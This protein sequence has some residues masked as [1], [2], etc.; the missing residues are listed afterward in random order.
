MM[1]AIMR[2]GPDDAALVAATLGGDGEA[3]GRIVARYQALICSLAYSATGSL[4]QGQDIAQETFVAAWRQ[5]RDLREPAKLRAWLCQIARNRICDTLRER[6]R[7][8]VS[9]AE[10]LEQALDFSAPQS[11]SQDQAITMKRR[12]FFGVRCNTFQK[13]IVSRWFCSIASITPSSR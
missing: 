12:R 6:E 5:L 13:P 8:P 1:K 9:I 3:F 11:S 7:D 10:P 2:A 4:S